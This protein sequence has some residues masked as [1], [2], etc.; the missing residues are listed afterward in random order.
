MKEKKSTRIDVSNSST[1]PSS[2]STSSASVRAVLIRKNSPEDL[3]L[4][5]L[6]QHLLFAKLR[7]LIPPQPFQMMEEETNVA[8][9]ASSSSTTPTPAL[10]PRLLQ[11][12]GKN[13]EEEVDD[14]DDE[15]DGNYK[16]E[17]EVEDESKPFMPSIKIIKSEVSLLISTVV[18]KDISLTSTL[19]HLLEQEELQIDYETQYRSETKVSHTIKVTVRPGY[20]VDEL[21]KKL[22]RW[23]GKPI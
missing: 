3:L 1:N 8:P 22:W 16:I 19:F 6:R 10:A 18:L 20:D 21:E 9:L 4:R 2:S 13:E 17:V 14:D 7:S 15:D 5:R 12:E 11:C 23:A